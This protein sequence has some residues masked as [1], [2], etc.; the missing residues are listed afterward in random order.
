MVDFLKC[1]RARWLFRQLVSL[2]KATPALRFT[3]TLAEYGPV[4]V[5]ILM[6]SR[7]E[8]VGASWCRQ[9]KPLRFARRPAGSHRTGECLRHRRRVTI[10]AEGI[11]EAATGNPSGKHLPCSK[12]ARFYIGALYQQKWTAPVSREARKNSK[13]LKPLHCLPTVDVSQD[14]F[15]FK[16]FLPPPPGLGFD[17]PCV[18]PAPF[19]RPYNF[20]VTFLN[21]QALRYSTISFSSSSFSSLPTYD[22]SFQFSCLWFPPAFPSTAL[23]GLTGGLSFFREP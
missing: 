13:A 10:A 1:L 15:L 2:G 5:P 3:S 22:H 20:I 4:V 9:H 11:L 21:V 7:R 18:L 23:A 14:Y 17:S 6:T 8:P 12:G 16:A 19:F